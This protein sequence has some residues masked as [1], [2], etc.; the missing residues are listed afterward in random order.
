MDNM[1]GDLMLMRV[2]GMGDACEL[3]SAP[4]KRENRVSAVYSYLTM[5]SG[6]TMAKPDITD[7][8]KD[9]DD[10]GEE[11]VAALLESKEFGDFAEILMED[12]EDA[13]VGSGGD[14]KADLEAA[15]LGG[16][17]DAG[18]PEEDEDLFGT[19][20]DDK[21]DE[22]GEVRESDDVVVA[23]DDDGGVEVPPDPLPGPVPAAPEPVVEVGV[24]GYVTSTHPGHED[25]V[26]GR[27][28]TNVGMIIRDRH[29]GH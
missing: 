4:P 24:E 9:E 3:K 11:E 8:A 13:L 22:G 19:A 16:G 27:V 2:N 15:L 23:L 5:S 26:I 28:V 1:H 12:I 17:G 7:D 21:S 14:A 20:G 6:E 18:V 25:I 10:D 29:L